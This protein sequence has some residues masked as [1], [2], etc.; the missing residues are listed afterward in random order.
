MQLYMAT[1]KNGS[2]HLDFCRD[3]H[4]LETW[5]ETSILVSSRDKCERYTHGFYKKYEF[6]TLR[7]AKNKFDALTAKYGIA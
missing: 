4:T 2:C 1:N 7:A 3:P 5:F 6:K